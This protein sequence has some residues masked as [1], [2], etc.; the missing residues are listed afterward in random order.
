VDSVT[1]EGLIDLMAELNRELGTTFVF[2]THDTRLMKRAR[3]LIKLV[4]GAVA[5]DEAREPAAPG[6]GTGGPG[7]RSRPRVSPGEG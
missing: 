2:A 7:A 4:D 3:R 1:S 5:A 6:D